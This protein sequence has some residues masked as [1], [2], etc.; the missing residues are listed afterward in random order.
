[1]HSD[2]V[3]K[4]VLVGDT[5]VGK[6]CLALRFADDTYT[7]NGGM[8]IG[9]DFKTRTLKLDGKTIRLLIW[10]T[11]AQKGFLPVTRAHFRGAHGFI[12]VYD[13]TNQES[14][15]NVKEW[16]NLIDCCVDEKV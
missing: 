4:L 1:M 16:M 15:S 10:D 11:N 3:F 9:I 5:P 6:S 2:F 13:V 7:E 14:F 12:V 8:T